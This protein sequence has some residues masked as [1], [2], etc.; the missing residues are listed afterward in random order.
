MG[1]VPYTTLSSLRT[2][3]CCRLM[4]MYPPHF[5][6]PILKKDSEII[7]K[8]DVSHVPIKAAPNDLSDSIFYGV[9]KNKLLKYITKKGNGSLAKQLLTDTLETI[10]RTQI[11]RLNLI[12]AEKENVIIDTERILVNAIENSRPL[13]QLS[14][15][16]RGGVKYQVPIPL[17]EKKSYFLAMK[18]LLD[19]A[20]EKDRKVHLPDKLAWEILDAAH[21]QGRV[22]KK[23][24]DLHR[25]CESNRAYA[26]YRWS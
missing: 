13:L 6:E 23:K 18:W 2:L 14:E 7:N 4:S 15:I 16:K 24:D 8:K 20:R 11:E 1:F 26:H 12:N 19:A 3:K 9:L 21:G 10:K 25:Q 17:T 22:I 5:A